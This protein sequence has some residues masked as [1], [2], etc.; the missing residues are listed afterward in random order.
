MAQ[1]DRIGRHMTSIYT[2]DGWTRVVYHET[3][4]V[5]FSLSGKGI[6]LDTGGYFTPTTKTRMNQASR[7]F[8][9]G[10]HVFQKAGKWYADHDGKTHAFDGDRLELESV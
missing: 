1:Q 4:V 6:V 10:Y 7:Q 2:Q 5:S 3:A 9:L 8:D